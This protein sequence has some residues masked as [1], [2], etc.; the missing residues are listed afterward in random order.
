MEGSELNFVLRIKE[1][2]TEKG[3][4]GPFCRVAIVIKTIF[5]FSF[6]L[7]KEVYRVYKE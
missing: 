4:Y 6:T 5:R 3:T 7:W 1:T 2:E